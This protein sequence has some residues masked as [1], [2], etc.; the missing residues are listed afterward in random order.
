M[1]GVRSSLY[2]YEKLYILRDYRSPFPALVYCERSYIPTLV[3]REGS[4]THICIESTVDTTIT[5]FY[6]PLNH[7]GWWLECFYSEGY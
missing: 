4:S 1:W 5:Y 7:L 2:I 3:Y 6:R